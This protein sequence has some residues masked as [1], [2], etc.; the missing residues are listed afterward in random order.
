MLFALCLLEQMFCVC[1]A[2]SFLGGMVMLAATIGFL[3]QGDH[4]YAYGTVMLS[5]ILFPFGYGFYRV[6]Y[7][8]GLMIKGPSNRNPGT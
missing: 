8:F 7:R 6:A 4:A 2:L 1:S 5:G 3:S